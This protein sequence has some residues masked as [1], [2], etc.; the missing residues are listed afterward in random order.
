MHFSNQF[1]DYEHVNV[2]SHLFI[3]LSIE[4]V[5]IAILDLMIQE[6]GSRFQDSSSIDLL[7]I[8]PLAINSAKWQGKE[9]EWMQCVLTAAEPYEEFLPSICTMKTD[10]RSWKSLW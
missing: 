5:N 1:R 2:C 10:L 8:M 6:F 7:N 4:F 9:S 3:L